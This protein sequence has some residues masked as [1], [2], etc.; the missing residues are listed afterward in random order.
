M[1][2]DKRKKRRR[3]NPQTAE[4]QSTRPTTRSHSQ[5]RPLILAI[6]VPTYWT[7]EEALAVFEMV[8]ALHDRIWSIYHNEL[9]DLIRQQRQSHTAEPFQ[10]DDDDLP[11]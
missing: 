9:Q 11:F 7:A 8:D 1:A 4:S 6:E 2:K 3:H 5:D 10:I